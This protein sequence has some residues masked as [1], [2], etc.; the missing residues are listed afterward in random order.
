MKAETIV[1]ETEFIRL[2]SLLKLAGCVESGGQAKWLIQQGEVRVNGE[3]CTQRG[4]KLRGGDAVQFG[5]HV[6]CVCAGPQ[7][8]A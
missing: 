2:D 6:F 8:P 5:A 3:V 7:E 1:I 4:K